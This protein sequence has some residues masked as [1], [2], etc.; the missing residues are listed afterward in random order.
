MASQVVDNSHPSVPSLLPPCPSHPHAGVC[1][2]RE[3]EPGR[4]AFGEHP[5]PENLPNPLLTEAVACFLHS[6]HGG[7]TPWA[8]ADE[9][10][11]ARLRRAAAEV[12]AWLAATTVGTPPQRTHPEG[13]GQLMDD[14][15]RSEA[16]QRMHAA[17]G[18]AART[19]QAAREVRALVEEVADL[20]A[21]Q[22]WGEAGEV[23][24]GLWRLF[25]FV[26]QE[27]AQL[28]SVYAQCEDAARMLVEAREPPRP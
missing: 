2:P 13:Q 26:Q 27:E 22:K 12:L 23:K 11:Q 4:C 17:A 20:L 25:G 6:Q 21:A 1:E 28:A 18:H 19:L 24:R 8:K 7:E 10:S 16:A 14:T 5:L 9:A 15:V 3:D